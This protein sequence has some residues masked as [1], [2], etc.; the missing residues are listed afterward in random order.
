MA[1]S[2]T[3]G[4]VPLTEEEIRNLLNQTEGLS[5]IKGKWVEVNHARL[6]KLLAEMKQYDGDI[7]LIEALR[8]EV[9]NA[10]DEKNNEPVVT[11][12]RWLSGLLKSLRSPPQ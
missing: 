4:G 1:P 3:V 5:L 2:L 11:N 12:G 10:D 7:T 6:K 9:Y 8:S